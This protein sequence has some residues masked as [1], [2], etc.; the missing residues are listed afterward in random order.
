MYKRARRAEV[1]GD[2]VVNI[3]VREM[4]VY[5]VELLGMEKQEDRVAVGVRFKVA[6]GTYI[7]SLAEALG[8]HLGIPACLADLRRTQVGEY[9]IEDAQKLRDI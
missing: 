2:T 3:P 5:E 9:R 6:S 4:T 8:R 7:R 1:T